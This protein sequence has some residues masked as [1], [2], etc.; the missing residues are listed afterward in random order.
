MLISFKKIVVGT[1]QSSTVRVRS[2]GSSVNLSAPGSEEDQQFRAFGACFRAGFSAKLALSGRL[3]NDFHP[4]TATSATRRASVSK[5]L[6]KQ[7]A[8]GPGRAPRCRAK[9]NS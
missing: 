2:W 1:T 5:D 9:P 6:K 7:R 3:G 4:K 8:Q